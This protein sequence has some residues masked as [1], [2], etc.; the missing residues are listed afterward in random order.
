MSPTTRKGV[1]RLTQVP[2][3][4]VTGPRVP[5]RKPPD[6]PPSPTGSVSVPGLTGPEE[7]DVETGEKEGDGDTEEFGVRGGKEVRVDR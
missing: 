7:G 5:L 4:G 1:P 6:Y 3:G 2:A